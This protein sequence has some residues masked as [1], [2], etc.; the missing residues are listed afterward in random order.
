MQKSG[1]AKVQ[2]LDCMPQIHGIR[3]GTEKY[4]VKGHNLNMLTQ[5]KHEINTSFDLNINQQ[6]ICFL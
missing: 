1:E 3:S 6:I 4:Y 2:L 5:M